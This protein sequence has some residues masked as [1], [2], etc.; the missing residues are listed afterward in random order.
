[1]WELSFL[2]CDVESVLLSL[3]AAR[4]LDHPHIKLEQNVAHQQVSGGAASLP[5]TNFPP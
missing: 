1:M 3:R 2:T 5:K 4:A